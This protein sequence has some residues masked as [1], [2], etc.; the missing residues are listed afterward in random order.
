MIM[1]KKIVFASLLFILL[2][3]CTASKREIAQLVSRDNYVERIVRDSI[4]LHDSV[5]V[6]QKS[7]TVFLE[8]VRTLY[9]DRM[10][11]DTFLLCDTIY[12]ERVVT[13][14]KKVGNNFSFRQLA[15]LFLLFFLL[16]KGVPQRIWQLMKKM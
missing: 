9:R 13:V 3:S 1:I 14:E 8:K 7:D 11:V 2:I 4:Y 12:N 10:S 5:Y 16:I 6:V 15:L